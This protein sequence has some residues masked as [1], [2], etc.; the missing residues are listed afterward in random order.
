M[1]SNHKGD[2]QTC[3]LYPGVLIYMNPAPII[4]YSRKQITVESSKFGSKFVS[5]R[6]GPELVKSLCYKL[7]MMGIPLDGVPVTVWV[8]NKSFAKNFSILE[9]ILKKSRSNMILSC[10]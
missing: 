7:I 3:I 10:A 9:S 5:L 1:D 8:H 2:P 4:W 6:V